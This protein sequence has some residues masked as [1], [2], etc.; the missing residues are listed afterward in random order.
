MKLKAGK[1][2]INGR[3]DERGPMEER[4]PGVWLDQH[5]TIY[6]P[7]GKE[8]NHIEGSTANLMREKTSRID[9]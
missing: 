8:W 7:D 2:Y 5:G 6:Q 3:G 4:A 1:I 9:R